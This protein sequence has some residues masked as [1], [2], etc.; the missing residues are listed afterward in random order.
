MSSLLSGIR[1][2]RASAMIAGVVVVTL[3]L[4]SIRQSRLQA[5]HELTRS[6]LRVA[7]LD[8][9]L[10]DR[11]GEIADRLAPTALRSQVD[12]VL[13]PHSEPSIT[14]PVESGDGP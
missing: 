1:W 9:E 5:A 10:L 12:A 2:L 3:G 4:L 14:D 7:E 13:F 11:R 8:R 6:R